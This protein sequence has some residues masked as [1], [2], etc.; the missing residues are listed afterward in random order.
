MICWLIPFV[1]LLVSIAICSS[2]NYFV[3]TKTLK[4]TLIYFGT[5]GFIMGV[6]SGYITYATMPITGIIAITWFVGIII[7]K[8]V[9]GTIVFFAF[10]LFNSK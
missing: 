8:L 1:N 9:A 5:V 3:K 10:K 2:Y 7:Q 6:S 4:N